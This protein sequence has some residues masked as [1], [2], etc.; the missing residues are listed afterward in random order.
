MNNTHQELI[1]EK[2]DSVR[3]QTNEFF[4]ALTFEQRTEINQWLFETLQDTID[5]VLEGESKKIGAMIEEADYARKVGEKT[6]DPIAV[7]EVQDVIRQILALT[8]PTK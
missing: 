1:E 3:N 8:P 5:T 2:V 7:W 4:Y 6:G